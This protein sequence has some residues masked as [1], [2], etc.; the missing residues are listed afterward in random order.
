MDLKKVFTI[1]QSLTP[2]VKYIQ[3][4][5][6]IYSNGSKRY[7]IIDWENYC[8]ALDKLKKI[9]P[10]KNIIEELYT[11]VPPHTRNHQ[12]PLVDDCTKSSI[13]NCV[14]I[15]VIKLETVCDLADASG[16]LA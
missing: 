7:Q 5:E 2:T 12:P 8:K 4:G 14:C 13:L 10:L 11:I 16:I 1:C 6:I 9:R 15:L 3:F